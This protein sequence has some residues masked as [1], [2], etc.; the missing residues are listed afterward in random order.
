MTKH[1]SLAAGLLINAESNAVILFETSM[2][3]LKTTYWI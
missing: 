1:E 2:L 3:L